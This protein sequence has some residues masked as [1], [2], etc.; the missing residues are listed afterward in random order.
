MHKFC[1][2]ILLYGLDAVPMSKGNIR[3]LRSLWRTALFKVFKLNDEA[4]LLYTQYCF[5]MLPIN[6]MLD[7][8]KLSL[9]NMQREHFL[10]IVRSL[11]AV[12]G[13]TRFNELCREYGIADMCRS[14]FRKRVWDV[15]IT[16]VAF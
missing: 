15:F 13:C 16:S 7:L 4:N 12:S 6:Y 8:Q 2:P 3:T 11:Y 1:V 9:L 14:I 10:P 5:N